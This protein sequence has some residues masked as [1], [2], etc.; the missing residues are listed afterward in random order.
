MNV[1]IVLDH[2]YI[3]G[4]KAKKLIPAFERVFSSPE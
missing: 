1:N 2:R 3:D 4:G